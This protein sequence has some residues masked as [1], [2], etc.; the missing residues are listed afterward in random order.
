MTSRAE[1]VTVYHIALSFRPNHVNSHN[2][3]TGLEES[4]RLTI[5]LVRMC[6]TISLLSDQKSS[7]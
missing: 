7:C 2:F 1:I 6:V 5:E 3:E 4:Y